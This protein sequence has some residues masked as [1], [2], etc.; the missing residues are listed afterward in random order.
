MDWYG[1]LKKYVWSEE[2]TPYLVSPRKLTPAQ[3]RSEIF[4]YTL[5]LGILFAVVTV[6]SAGAAIERGEFGALAATAYGASVLGA[7]ILLGWRKD[8]RAALFCLSAPVAVLL[9][10]FAGWLHPGL[11]GID[12]AVILFIAVLW[13]AYAFRAMGVARA[14]RDRSQAHEAG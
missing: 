10:L 13:L 4:V 14:Y 8:A 6:A 3:A 2:R 11:A 1:S 5:F 9:A 12:K 7:A